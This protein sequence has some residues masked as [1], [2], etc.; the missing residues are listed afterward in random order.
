L[1]GILNVAVWFGAVIFFTVGVVPGLFST[2]MQGILQQSYTVL[3]GRL[4]MVVVS[5]YFLLHYFCASIA[6]LHQLAERFYL[7]KRLQPL[8]FG[9]L[10]GLCVLSLFAG[11]WLQPRLRKLHEIKYGRTELYSPAIKAQAAHAFSF[12]HGVSFVTN[13]LIM[14]GLGV[15]LWRLTN[16]GNGPRF[17]PSGGKFRS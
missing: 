1:I 6:L 10:I 3:S 5:R 11:F 8:T 14:G 12:W 4:A 15:Y 9:I 17:I 2:E 13:L 7:S 16:P